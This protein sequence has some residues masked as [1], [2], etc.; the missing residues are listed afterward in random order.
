MMAPWI[1]EKSAYVASDYKLAQLI[2]ELIS[3]SL[4]Y[5]IVGEKE[6]YTLEDAQS[7]QKRQYVSIQLL[8]VSSQQ[9]KRGFNEYKLF[10]PAFIVS[11]SSDSIS[12][13]F[14]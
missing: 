9:K 7:L 1:S 14:I 10:Q 11:I 8:A 6:V 4:L 2:P 3:I 13:A 12:K 5:E